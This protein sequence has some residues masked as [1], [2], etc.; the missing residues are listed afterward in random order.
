LYSLT[1]VTFSTP[2][3]TNETSKPIIDKQTYLFH[4]N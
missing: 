3:K 1:K 4:R 2:Q